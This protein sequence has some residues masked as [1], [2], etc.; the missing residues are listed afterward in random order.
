MYNKILHIVW[1]YGTVRS[2]AMCIHMLFQWIFTAIFLIQL[3]RY[4]RTL[5]YTVHLPM[6]RP[7]HII[8][9]RLI[10]QRVSDCCLTPTQQFF[11]YILARTSLFSMRWWWAPLC[12]RPTHLVGFLVVSASSLKQQSTDRHVATLGHI[13]LISSQ[14]VFALS[15]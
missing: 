12:T 3:T 2:M 7:W 4:H 13:I 11:S 5:I 8:V 1:S 10:W 6:L 15:P 14:P 9:F